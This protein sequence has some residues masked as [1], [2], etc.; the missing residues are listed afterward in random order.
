M[1]I[2]HA[3]GKIVQDTADGV[4]LVTFNN[5][6]K[7]NA[8]SLDMWDG[9]AACLTAFAED[10]AV[11]VVV[12]T[13]AGDKAFVSGADISQFEAERHNAE[14]AEAYAQRSRQ[15]AARGQGGEGH[16]RRDPAQ[17][18]GTRPGIGQAARG[19]MYG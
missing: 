17:P 11:R 9:L 10:S 14:A 8:M 6:A 12:L 3:D 7:R 2:E 15:R 18:G 5:P 16:H 19:R 13:G 4:G 1:P